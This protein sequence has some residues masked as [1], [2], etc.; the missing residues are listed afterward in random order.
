MPIC[1]SC[2]KPDNVVIIPDY[3]EAHNSKG[4]CDGCGYEWWIMQSK[5]RYLGSEEE[6]YSPEWTG[7]TGEQLP[8]RFEKTTPTMGEWSPEAH[9][10]WMPA[11]KQNE[12]D[13][14][15]LEE[16]R[17]AYPDWEVRI[18]KNEGV[19]VDEDEWTPTYEKAEG[20]LHIGP[21]SVVIEGKRYIPASQLDSSIEYHRGVIQE[22]H[23]RATR[24]VERINEQ[25]KMI[26]D[27]RRDLADMHRQRNELR[28]MIEK[29]REALIEMTRRKD[30][31]VEELRSC[32]VA[33]HDQKQH[34]I[35]L[36][37]AELQSMV[38]YLASV[39]A[40]YT[41]KGKDTSHGEE[42]ELLKDY[43]RKYAR[44]E[45]LDEMGG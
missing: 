29:E 16:L 40:T 3:D 33:L 37:C 35:G 28:G 15:K 42:A 44:G 34:E 1:P 12:E 13:L 2:R 20:G 6:K 27:L 17:K 18:A 38:D 25:A 41:F 8:P 30:E 21:V 26:L 7:G 23:D 22:L 31:Y 19:P 4:V 36:K 5:L 11:L 9:E 45:P 39:A 24:R 43:A 32:N 10:E 14:R